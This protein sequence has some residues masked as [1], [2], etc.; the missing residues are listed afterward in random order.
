MKDIAHLFVFM[1]QILNDSF[2]AYQ[3]AEGDPLMVEPHMILAI[4]SLQKACERPNGPKDEDAFYRQYQEPFHQR[5]YETWLRLSARLRGLHQSQDD[6]AVM[7]RCRP[8]FETCR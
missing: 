7:D 6:V 4:L 5:L 8:A 3:N 2:F 1:H